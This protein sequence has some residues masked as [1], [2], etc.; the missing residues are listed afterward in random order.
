MAYDYNS[1]VLLF[2]SIDNVEHGLGPK[3]AHARRRS[4]R[5]ARRQPSSDPDADE[6]ALEQPEQAHPPEMRTDGYEEALPAAETTP[7]GGYER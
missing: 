1:C 7:S 6:K 4:L 5:D 2:L 3:S